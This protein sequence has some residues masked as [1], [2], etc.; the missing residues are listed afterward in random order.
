MKEWTPCHKI[1][2]KGPTLVTSNWQV[3]SLVILKNKDACQ[4]GKEVT[5]TFVTLRRVSDSSEAAGA[6]LFWDVNGYRYGEMRQ[7]QKTH[8]FASLVFEAVVGCPGSG[9]PLQVVVQWMF[10]RSEKGNL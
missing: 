9:L 5:A 4:H 7:K 2:L 10:R 8:H 1:N 3:L 6:S